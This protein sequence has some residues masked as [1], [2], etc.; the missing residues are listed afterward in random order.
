MTAEKLSLETLPPRVL[1]VDDDSMLRNLLFEVLSYEGYTVEAAIDGEDALRRLAAAS[2]DLV[3]TDVVMPG[4]SGVDVLRT[5]RRRYPDIDVIVMT[6]YASIETAIR[7]IRLGA[8]D[9]IT[10]PFNIEYVRVL[11]AKTIEI[12]RL[13]RAQR[14]A[15]V[16]SDLAGIDISTG[17]YNRPLFIDLLQGELRSAAQSRHDLSLIVIELLS[18]CKDDGSGEAASC[19]EWITLPARTLRRLVRP[20]DQVGRLGPLSFGVLLPGMASTDVFFEQD[21]LRYGLRRAFRDKSIPISVAVGS[22]TYPSDAQDMHSLLHVAE[23][24]ALSFPVAD[25]E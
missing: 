4:I 3:I 7:S 21:R 8:V 22:A 6:G 5:A 2:F 18:P 15:V 10:K 1:V 16:M 14:D 9:Y 20:G 19:A 11:V 12:S 25:D 23:R 17:L 13:R 24:E